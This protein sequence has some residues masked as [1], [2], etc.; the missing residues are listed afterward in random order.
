MAE[1][2]LVR[3]MKYFLFKVFVG[4][5]FLH[6]A[7]TIWLFVA[8]ISAVEAYESRRDVPVAYST[9]LD[10]DADSS[11]ARHHLHFGPARFIYYLA[12]PWSV[13]V[14]LG[15]GFSCQTS[16]A[17]GTDWPNQTI[18]RSDRSLDFSLAMKFHPAVAHSL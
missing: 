12:L 7:V 15:C 6:I 10:L 4:A 14:A 3:P 1:L 5:A 11:V 18:Q 8:N 17:G 9:V 16:C 2:L 13:L